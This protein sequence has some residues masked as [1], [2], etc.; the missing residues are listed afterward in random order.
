MKSVFIV[1]V[2]LVLLGCAAFTGEGAGNPDGTAY[3]GAPGSVYSSAANPPR[4]I[5]VVSY[6]PN[7]MQVPTADL[8]NIAASPGIANLPP[9]DYGPAPRRH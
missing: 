1:A 7:A 3:A 8:P 2:A 9:Q 5:G 4:I 6:D